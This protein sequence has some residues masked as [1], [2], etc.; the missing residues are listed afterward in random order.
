MLFGIISHEFIVS[1]VDVLELIPK[2]QK[3]FMQDVIKNQI[4]KYDDNVLRN[5]MNAKITN[6]T[7]TEIDAQLSCEQKDLK[8]VFFVR[9]P[10]CAST[11]FVD[12]L[13]RLDSKK[14]INLSFN[15]SGAYNW[16]SKTMSNVAEQVLN[17]SRSSQLQYIY[18]RHFYFVN[19]NN[20]NIGGEFTYITIVRE[21][22]SRII[23]AYHYYHFSSRPHIQAMLNPKHRNESLKECFDH[24]HEGCERN[25]MTKYF[26]GHEP[27]CREGSKE[28]YDLAK[29]NIRYYFI[30]VGILEDM[31]LTFKL[32]QHFL[33]RHFLY[34]DPESDSH[35]HQNKNKH[36][37][38]ISEELREEIQT[39]NQYD[40][41]LYYHI[42]EELYQ[43]GRDCLII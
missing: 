21:P 23:S 36:E 43:L 3:L 1:D 32:L 41:L 28:S 33:P 42:R 24:A 2:Q 10:K 11:S 5:I 15:P 25:L 31:T 39:K 8:I 17:E 14:H 9:L 7:I 40:M 22:V 26:C 20:Y 18:A 37:T 13:K 27:V 34:L 4:K 38:D 35:Q 12:I 30:V 16:D 19:F 6:N 29:H